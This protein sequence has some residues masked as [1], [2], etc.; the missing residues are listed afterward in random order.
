MRSK[1]WLWFVPVVGAALLALAV[2]A[3]VAEAAAETWEIDPV[4]SSILFRV[5]HL[6]VSHVYGRF[7]DFSGKITIDDGDL[8]NAKVQVE[9]KTQSVNTGNP[10]RDDHLRSPASFGVQ[11]FPTIAFA[12]TSVKK[13]GDDYEVAGNLT[14]HGVTKPVT[15]TMKKL[16]QGPGMGGKT[17][18]GFEG[19]LDLKRSDYGMSTMVGPVSDEV[20]L[21]LAFEAN[22]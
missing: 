7:D 19:T 13:N 10:K 15:V 9:V 1:L 6:N 21:N 16:G 3:R 5:K 14:I 20:H 8:A 2:P 22:R 18:A 17:V 4:H 11:Q 12:S